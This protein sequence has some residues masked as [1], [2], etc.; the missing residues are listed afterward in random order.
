RRSSF[1]RPEYYEAYAAVYLV[2]TRSGRLVLWKNEKH[3]A[4][5]A[6][7]AQSELNAS[8]AEIASEISG[9]AKAI[10]AA[11]LAEPAPMP[12]EEPPDD[13]SPLAKNFKPPIPYRRIKPEYTAEAAFYDLTATVEMTIDL[14]ADGRIMRTEITRWAGYGLDESVE[15]VVRAMNWRPAERSGKTLPMRFFVRYNFRKVEKAQQ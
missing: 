5:T 2:S 9:T 1:D 15:K 10:T 12:I 13:A 14:D 3:E 8:A 7:K 4:A 6:D 11:E